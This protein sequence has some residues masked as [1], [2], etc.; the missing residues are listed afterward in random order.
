MKKRIL[1]LLLLHL[2]GVNLTPVAFAQ[3]AASNKSGNFFYFDFVTTD[4]R[5]MVRQ[6]STFGATDTAVSNVM[7]YRAGHY[8]NSQDEIPRS[9]IMLGVKLNP[10]LEDFF[11]NPVKSISKEYSNYIIKDSS[12]A[13]LIAMGI[14]KS[15]IKNYRYHVVQNDSLEIIPWSRI[16]QLEQKY[17]AKQPY[18]YLGKFQSPGK[19][20]LVEVR[21]I[22]DYSIRDGVIF[23]WRVNFKPVV[24]EIM[25]ETPDDG[26][27]INDYTKKINYFNLNYSKMNKGYATRFDS[28]TGMPLDLKFPVDSVANIRLSYKDHITIPYVIYLVK[29][30]SGKTDTTTIGWYN[31]ENYANVEAKYYNQPGKYE[32]IIQRANDLGHWSENQVLRIPF[33]VKPLPILDKKVSI[34]QAFPYIMA[35][36]TGVALLFGGYYR[37]NQVKLLRAAQEKQT[38]GLK[39]QSIRTQLNPHFMFNALTSIQNLVNKNDMIGANHYLSKFAGLTRQVLDTGNEEL[40]SIEQEIRILDDYLQMEQLRFSFKY[41]IIVVADLNKANTEIPAMLLQ[42]FVENA[43]KHGVAVLK[44]KG[45]IEIAVIRD[46]KDLVFSIRDNGKWVTANNQTEIRGYGLKLSEERVALLNQ[47]YKDQP[48][49]LYIEKAGEGTIVSIRLTNWL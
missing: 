13:I 25:L 28:K 5:M 21:N 41:E 19:Q 35:T 18:G 4:Q 23:D 34:K 6:S 42:P 45:K 29:N 2:I 39:L 11:S 12:A 27:G 22:N 47:L 30:I 33:E 36:L 46:A 8:F 15:N 17:G 20:I 31:L 32:I 24:T 44:D 16:P 26:K 9:P 7:E 49:S 1:A 38:A 48:V 14:D 3:T 43:V 10:N 40:L 37:H